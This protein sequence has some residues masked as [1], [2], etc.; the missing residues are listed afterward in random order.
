MNTC[1]RPSGSPAATQRSQNPDTMSVPEVP[2]KPA[3]MSHADNS[4]KEASFMWGLY[5]PWWPR[6]RGGARCLSRLPD[7]HALDG[8]LGR[9]RFTR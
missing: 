9:A 6:R 2:A 8:G 5:R 1:M 4:V 3:W 7:E